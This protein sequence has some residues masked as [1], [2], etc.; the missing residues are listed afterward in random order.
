MIA[1]IQ[2]SARLLLLEILN[3]VA[4]SEDTNPRT[5]KLN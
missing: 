2:K 3:Q 1:S 4:T 5:L